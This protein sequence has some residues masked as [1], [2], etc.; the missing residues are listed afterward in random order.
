M[1]TSRT[2]TGK[3]KRVRAKAIRQARDRGLTNCPDCN[4][5]LDYDT[6]YRPESAE[7]DHIIPHSRGGED[8]IENTRV[9]CRDCNLKKSNST[10]ATSAPGGFP[11]S[12]PW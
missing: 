7:A 9:I 8:T 11:L 3:W 6:P 5:G 4:Q 2:G 1:A 12:R 10:T